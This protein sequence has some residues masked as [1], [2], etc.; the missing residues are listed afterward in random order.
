MVKP[1]PL[2]PGEKM[3]DDSSTVGTDTEAAESGEMAGTM[4]DLDLQR[5][6]NPPRSGRNGPLFKLSIALTL[7]ARDGLRASDETRI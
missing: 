7:P 4:D 6:P 3:A 1:V 2:N 5:M